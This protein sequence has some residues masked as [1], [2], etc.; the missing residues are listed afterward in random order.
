MTQVLDRTVQLTR[1]GDADGLEIIDVP[2][3][4]PGPGEVGSGYS[5]QA[6][7]TLTFSF[8]S[9]CTRKRPLGA[10]RS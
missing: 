1:F 3:P 2:L 8:G 7:T 6:S 4:K 9:T 5:P 10:C